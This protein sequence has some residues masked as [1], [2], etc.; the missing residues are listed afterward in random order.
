MRSSFVRWIVACVGLI[1]FPDM[2]RAAAPPNDAFA[3]PM[4]IT[5][6]PVTALGTNME[7]TMETG[8]PVPDGYNGVVRKSIWFM[9]TAP[10]SGLVQIDTFGSARHSY[11]GPFTTTYDM[12]AH[13][14]VW[15]GD[16]LDALTEI[17]SGG[18]TE[19]RYIQ[20]LSGTT[21]RIAVYGTSI[22]VPFDDGD[23][24]L[25]ITNETSSHITGLVTG[26]DGATP[27]SN[28]IVQAHQSETV[29]GYTQWKEKAWAFTD[30]DGRYTIRGLT[31]GTVRIG[32][33]D[34]N[35]RTST[36]VYATAYYD[37]QPNIDAATDIPVPASGAV[38]GIN[39]SLDLTA[40]VSGRITGPDGIT[41]LWGITVTAYHW[42][43]SLENWQ[44]IKDDSTDTNGN[45]AIEGLTPETIRLKFYSETSNEHVTEYYDNSE[46]ILSAADI[47]LTSG[48]R[49]TG[50]NAS[51]EEAAFLEGTI[52]G[53][54]GTTP[55]YAYV[56][57]YRWNGSSWQS[58]A[59]EFTYDEGHY[60]FGGLSTGRYRIV[61]SDYTWDTD[62]YET[63]AYLGAAD[64]DYA[65]D[66]VVSGPGTLGGFDMTLALALP[67]IQAVE[68]DE[69]QATVRFTGVAGR[70]YILQQGELDGVWTNVGSSLTCAVGT[71]TLTGSG[72]P[73]LRIWRVRRYP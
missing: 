59:N 45:Y 73:A 28:I 12:V 53:P 16:S 58:L 69:D 60:S 14:A 42:L 70:Q 62:D 44:W 71:N 66:I 26:P 65:T 54:D 27:L 2:G 4:S 18:N 17:R 23:I 22:G 43:P 51:M 3:S 38:T 8:E 21:Y 29:W 47:A 37:G 40:S 63:Q 10:T 9:W 6:F 50:I 15:V 5:G 64:I 36:L 13:P 46:S 41:P 68:L 35:N 32:F 67:V 52:T 49:V 72:N 48:A 25:H 30:G 55:I 11:F 56:Y 57:L 20:V 1:G 33:M 24:V 19:S 31:G 61:V 34:W 39:A 7:A